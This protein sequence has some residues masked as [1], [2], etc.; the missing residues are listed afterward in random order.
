M[1]LKNHKGNWIYSCW[2]GSGL[3]KKETRDAVKEALNQV[4]DT[5]IKK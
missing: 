5:I 1:A 3:C 2:H 4:K